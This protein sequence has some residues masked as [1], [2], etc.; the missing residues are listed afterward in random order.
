MRLKYWVIS[1]AAIL[2]AL[3]LPGLAQ[4]QYPYVSEPALSQTAAPSIP[5]ESS[6][7]STPTQTATPVPSTPAQPADIQPL[8]FG[9]L[10]DNQ[11]ISFASLGVV[12]GYCGKLRSFLEQS[13]RY[14]FQ[15]ED[16][17]VPY[18]KRFQRYNGID[19]ECG[20]NTIS[21]SRKKES[22]FQLERGEFS[23]P[24]FTT[25]AKILIRNGKL[26]LLNKAESSEEFRVGVLEGTTTRKV[27]E[28]A[29]PNATIAIVS[30][31]GSAIRRLQLPL[32]SKEAIHAYMTDE[33]LLVSMLE[34]LDREKLNDYSIEPK[35]YGL[36]RESYGVVVYNN[37]QLLAA[38]NQWIG[39][40]GQ[41]AKQDLERKAEQ[42]WLTGTLKFLLSRNH[43]FAL[44]DFLLVISLL[45]FLALLFTHP[46]FITLI[47]KLPFF[48][49]FV[50][51]MRRREMRGESSFVDPLIGKILNNETFNVVA[52][53]ANKSFVPMLI[54]RDTVVTLLKGVGQPFL[55]MNNESEPSTVEVEKIAQ[56]LAQEAEA[57]PHF[58][59]ALETVQ[60]AASEEADK[61]LRSVVTRAFELLK[62][63]VDPGSIAS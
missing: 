20:A 31:R 6:T 39:D 2:F 19:I 16:I 34:A 52:Y 60:D 32:E 22:K 10:D 5:A 51:W 26:H 30:N 59:K 38:I 27:V 1:S 13:Y 50:N 15:E 53:K 25:G 35:A 8:K 11:P 54:D 49:R 63:T 36:T 42:H 24:F 29:Y 57:N 12:E 43:F 62:Q 48:T 55:Q 41:K 61:W 28:A 21:N 9:F 46:F 4:G 14:R 56:S 23:N 45:L 58:A 37:P 3:V 17:K 47:A 40:E 18:E 7:P 33:I 44:A